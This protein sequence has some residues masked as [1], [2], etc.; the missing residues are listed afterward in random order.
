M[1]DRPKTGFTMPIESWLKGDLRFL[2]EQYI[3]KGNLNQ[4]IF[5]VEQVLQIKEDFLNNRLGH[6]EKII[7]RLLEFLLW[8]EEHLKA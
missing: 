1:M 5:H 8:K 4:E 2:L 7:W 6:E 3:D